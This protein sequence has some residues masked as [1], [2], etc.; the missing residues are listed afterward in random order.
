M[1]K[2][3]RTKRKSYNE[4]DTIFKKSFNKCYKLQGLQDGVPVLTEKRMTIIFFGLAVAVILLRI[5]VNMRCI[6]EPYDSRRSF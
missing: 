3:E 2:W 5:V 6:Y 1:I 4:D